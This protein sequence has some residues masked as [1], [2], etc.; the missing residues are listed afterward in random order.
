MKLSTEMKEFLKKQKK[1]IAE[2]EDKKRKINRLK[3]T[4]DELENERRE[5][6]Q[7]QIDGLE[8]LPP[9]LDTEEKRRGGEAF[10]FNPVHTALLLCVTLLA[11]AAPR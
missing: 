4:V 11:S 7:H 2:E 6:R 10:N 9:V 5:L 3:M 8:R 1:Y